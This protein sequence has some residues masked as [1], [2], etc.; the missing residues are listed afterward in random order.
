MVSKLRNCCIS[1]AH[2][3]TI[4]AGTVTVII[5]SWTPCGRQWCRCCVTSWISCC[6]C[7]LTVILVG[8]KFNNVL[9]FS[10]FVENGTYCDS[11]ES[12]SLRNCFVILSRI[13]LFLSILRLEYYLFF[14]S[15]SLLP[16]VRHAPF[17]VD[18]FLI[19]VYLWLLQEF[20]TILIQKKS[21]FPF[22]FSLIIMIQYLII[23]TWSVI[24]MRYMSLYNEQVILFLLWSDKISD[25]FILQSEVCYYCLQ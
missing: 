4:P 11:L 25:C 10:P 5:E 21:S 19:Q 6:W 8:T 22:T 23:K 2:L 20:A 9:M 1:S 7:T 15:M 24:I 13:H 3:N 17:T 16:F 18:V 14:S 12:H